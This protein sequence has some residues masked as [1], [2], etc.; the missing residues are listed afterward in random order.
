MALNF[1][2]QVEKLEAHAE[3]KDVLS[4]LSKLHALHRIV[5]SSGEFIEVRNIP[6]IPV[7]LLKFPPVSYYSY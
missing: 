5:E 1:L 6:N 4:T 7:Y 3:I 2:E